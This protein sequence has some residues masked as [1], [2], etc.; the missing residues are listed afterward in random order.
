[1]NVL[2]SFVVFAALAITTEIKFMW[3]CPSDEIVDGYKVYARRYG[4]TTWPI[5]SAV[6]GKGVKE[7]SLPFV[8]GRYE[9]AVSSYIRGGTDRSVMIESPRSATIEFT[10]P[11][12]P[13][14]FRLTGATANITGV[15]EFIYDLKLLFQN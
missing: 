7:V 5:Q 12:V 1:M 6:T 4:S 9:V 11:A 10:V 15:T 2:L 8:P 14:Q 3:D 13:T